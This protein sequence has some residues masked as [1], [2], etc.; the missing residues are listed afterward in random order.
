MCNQPL[1]GDGF[2]IGAFRRALGN[3]ATGV[4][5]V[6]AVDPGGRKAG[7]TANSFNAVSLEPPLILW[8][9]SKRSAS[10]EVFAAAT[11]FAVNILAA[12]QKA[13]SVNFA[14]PV[15]DRFVDIDHTPGVGRAAACRL[16]GASA[17]RK[18]SMGRRRRSLD[19]DRQSGGVR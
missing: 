1:A 15:L 11:H 5:V 8:S 6:T 10:C 14:G 16:C 13:V 12:G 9:I 2:D 7:M 3:F 18:P 17:V 19:T 4:T